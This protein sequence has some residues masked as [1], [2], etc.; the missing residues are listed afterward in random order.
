VVLGF[1]PYSL[2]DA[3]LLAASDEWLAGHED[4]PAA[5]RRL[6]RENRDPVARGLRAQER[7]ARG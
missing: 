1:Y 5:L 2:A 4:A 6:V 7:D 3:G